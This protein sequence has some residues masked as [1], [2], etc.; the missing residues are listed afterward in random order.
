MNRASLHSPTQRNARKACGQRLTPNSSGLA[1]PAMVF[2]VVVVS[3][4]LSS[5]LLMLTQAQQGQVLQIQSARALAAAKSAAEW[6][7]WKVS[8]PEAA[9]GLNGSTLPDCFP[10]QAIAIPAPLDSVTVNITCSR[11]PASGT[12][13]EGGLRLASYRIV[14]VATSGGTGQDMVQRQIEARHTVCKNPGGTGP[15]Y[16]C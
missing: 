15:K 5:G 7:L 11:L 9:L 12:I 8:D 10:D 6:G 16:A 14:A 2:M 13:D 4:M 3:L 1:L